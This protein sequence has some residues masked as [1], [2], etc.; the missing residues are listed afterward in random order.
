[1]CGY[2]IMPNHIHVLLG[3]RASEQPINTIVSNG[4]RFM[5]YELVRRLQLQSHYD[6]LE[7]L[8]R[9]VS[10][11]DR[12]QGKLHQVFEPSFDCKECY[13]EAFFSNSTHGCI[14]HLKFT[15]PILSCAMYKKSFKINV[16]LEKTRWRNITYPPEFSLY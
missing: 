12:K 3:I 14:N 13:S 10:A 6:T 11:P 16:S 9:A 2:V 7:W 8:S 5:A 1:V 15:S 4:K